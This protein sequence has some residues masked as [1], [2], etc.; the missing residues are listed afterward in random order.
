MVN[1]DRRRP[2]TSSWPFSTLIASQL[3]TSSTALSGVIVANGCLSVSSF[4]TPNINS[5]FRTLC[6]I[7]HCFLRIFNLSI[8]STI[9]LRFPVKQKIVSYD[10][11]PIHFHS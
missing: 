5:A 6:L 9:R 3:T 4:S 1:P 7:L 2:T 11:R 10:V 8:V